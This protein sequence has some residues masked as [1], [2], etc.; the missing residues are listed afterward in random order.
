MYGHWE[1][2]NNVLPIFPYSDT[3]HLLANLQ[4]EVIDPLKKWESATDKERVKRQ[5]AAEREQRLRQEIAE[6]K[7]QLRRQ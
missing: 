5:E 7:A 4:T 6:L 3:N 2:F 1:K